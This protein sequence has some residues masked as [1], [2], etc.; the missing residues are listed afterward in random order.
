MSLGEY[1]WFIEDFP[2]PPEPEEEDF[3]P[4]PEEG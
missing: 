4:S 1:R 3:P 2:E